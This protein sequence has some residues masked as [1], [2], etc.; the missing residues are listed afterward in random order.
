MAVGVAGGKHDHA[1][2][3]GWGSQMGCRCKTGYEYWWLSRYKGAGPATGKTGFR[4]GVRERQ[5]KGQ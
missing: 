4:P 1:D 2:G 3:P 5:R